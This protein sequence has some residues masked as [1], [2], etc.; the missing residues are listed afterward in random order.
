MTVAKSCPGEMFSGLVFSVRD[1]V[2]ALPPE[3][4]TAFA[5]QR[6]RHTRCSN[7]LD[8]LDQ[9]MNRCGFQR[10][11]TSGNSAVGER[12]RP[13]MAMNDLGAAYPPPTIPLPYQ[14]TFQNHLPYP[15]SSP[16]LCPTH[17]PR[18]V[19]EFLVDAHQGGYSFSRG[20]GR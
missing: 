1:I 16:M 5:L 4:L 18:L 17:P 15:F 20:P 14:K 6:A 11:I 9:T 19:H 12:R 7:L 13:P 8:V 3:N 10:A 2:L